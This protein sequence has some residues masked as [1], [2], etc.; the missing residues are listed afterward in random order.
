M[1]ELLDSDVELRHWVASAGQ[2]EGVSGFVER[3]EV[4]FTR[5]SNDSSPLRRSTKGT[6]GTT[7][8]RSTGGTTAPRSCCGRVN[9]PS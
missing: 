6:W 2:V 4:C 7:A 1:I 8:T 5:A 9:E 3:D